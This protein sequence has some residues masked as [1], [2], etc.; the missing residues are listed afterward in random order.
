MASVTADEQLASA[1]SPEQ[2]EVR[3]E[4]S[5]SFPNYQLPESQDRF[6][7]RRDFGFLPIPKHLQ[8]DPDHPHKWT[9][10]L[11]ISFGVASTFFAA[12]LYYCQPL[13][14][15]LAESFGVSDSE[16]SRVPT[17]IQAGYAVGLLLISPLGDLLR[18]RPLLLLLSVIAATLSIGLPLTHSIVAFEALSFLVG[19]F[20]V[21]PQILMPLAADLAPPERRAAALSIVLSGL[22]LGVLIARVI[23]GVIANFASWRIVYYMAIGAQYSVVLL[24]YWM[25][26]D[27]PQKN[28]GLT[29]FGILWTMGKYAVTEP[30]LIQ[31]VFINLLGMATFTNFWVTLTFLLG[32]PPYNYDTLIIGLFGL[33]GILGVCTAPFVGRLVDKLHPW[34]ATIVSIIGM[35]IF[36]AIETGA[37]GINIAAVVI[38]C[39]GIDVF[40]QMQQVSLTTSVFG[41]EPTAR[42]RLNAVMLI[43]IFVGQVI[44]T[45][46]GTSIFNKS[47]WRPAAALSVGLSSLGA[48]IMLARGPGVARY[49]WIGWKRES[50]GGAETPAT[51]MEKEQDPE[52]TMSSSAFFIRPAKVEDVDSILRL[53]IGLATYEKAADSV[54]ATPELLRKNLFETPFAHTLLAFAGSPESPGQAIGLAM[55]FFNYSTWTGRPGLYLEDLYVSPEYRG[56][57][58]GKSLF[59][60]LAK[61]AQEKDCARMDWSVLKWNKPSID[62]YEKTLHAAAMEE[63]MGMRLEEVGIENLKKFS[64]V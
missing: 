54:K 42:S 16:I 48:L 33:V 2:T 22:L 11:N 31:A 49:T 6:I 1:T 13:L 40:R 57:G 43:A 60:E 3:R 23:S 30:L 29:Y 21:V 28:E 32:G 7:Y 53:I 9:L 37:G 46:V 14:I 8:H 4:V 63:W 52:T 38:A 20:S 35:L 45:A 64:Q 34:F 5:P 12:N 62:F 47:G 15:K 19:L 58:I 25:I 18:R 10:V 51:V 59:A 17:L 56:T 55:Y 27:Y 50:K 26:P 24:M 41:L 61:V 44:G 39:F 36:Q